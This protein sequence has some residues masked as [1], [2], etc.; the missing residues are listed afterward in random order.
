MEWGT[1]GDGRVENGMGY[2]W[3]WKSREW[4]GVQLGMEE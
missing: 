1:T 2:N 3:G 4:N